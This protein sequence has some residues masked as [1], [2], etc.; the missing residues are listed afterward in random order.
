MIIK[1]K[2]LKIRAFEFSISTINLVESFPT[3][4]VYTTIG[5]QLIRCGTSIGANIMEAQAGRSRKDFSNYY[6]IAL[7]S[8]IETNYWLQIVQKKLPYLDGI[9]DILKETEELRK[10]LSASI[11]TLKMKE[12]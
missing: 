10:M 6:Q 8:T 9:T 7:K 3:N 1:S 5:K 4:Y 12:S 2:D 11:L